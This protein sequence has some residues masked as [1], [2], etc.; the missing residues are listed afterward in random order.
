MITRVYL[1]L[2]SNQ[3]DRQRNI[4]EAI[5]L[6]VSTVT[7]ERASSIYETEPWGYQDQPKF[8][9]AV[10]S[11]HTA[12]SP[13]QLLWKVKAVEVAM[14]RVP[15]FPNGPRLIDIDILMYSSRVIWTQ[16]LV[17]P[18]PGLSQR[19]FVLVP[20]SEIAGDLMHPLLGVTIDQ[21]L[22]QHG[23]GGEGVQQYGSLTLCGEQVP[24]AMCADQEGGD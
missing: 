8:L 19:S 4:E 5:A 24:S 15:S 7:P 16:D 2:G 14:G 12:L 9:N 22:R 18:H 10:Y 17:V 3:G 11:G 21:L 13:Q 1:G 20:L 6:L 23:G